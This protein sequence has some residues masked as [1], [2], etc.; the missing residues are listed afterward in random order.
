MR[1]WLRST[2]LSVAAGNPGVCREEGGRKEIDLTVLGAMKLYRPR[3]VYLLRSE[4]PS[5][6]RIMSVVKCVRNAPSFDASSSSSPHSLWRIPRH[7]KIGS[8]LLLNLNPRFNSPIYRVN[9]LDVTKEIELFYVLLERCLSDFSSMS[10][11]H[12]VCNLMGNESMI[13]PRLQFT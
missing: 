2:P 5:L 4:W 8:L 11:C 3:R 10:L 12:L 1:G 6:R 9:P 7:T 13:M